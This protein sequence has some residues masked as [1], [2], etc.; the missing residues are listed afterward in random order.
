M[1]HTEERICPMQGKMK[2]S[3]SWC[4]LAQYDEICHGC[5]Y[6]QD[7]QKSKYQI[8]QSKTSATWSTK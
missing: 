6:N 8:N 7:R 4:D 2:V 5:D 3:V 1:D